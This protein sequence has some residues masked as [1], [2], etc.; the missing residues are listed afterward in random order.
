M[1]G[2]RFVAWVIYGTFLNNLK[3]RESDLD[4]KYENLDLILHSENKHQKSVSPH[5]QNDQHL[6][7]NVQLLHQLLATASPW[8]CHCNFRVRTQKSRVAEYRV[9]F[10]QPGCLSKT[11][12]LS[13]PFLRM[14]KYY[15]LSQKNLVFFISFM[16]ACQ[17]LF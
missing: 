14:V 5:H 13:A 15:R 16:R 10:R 9:I 1:T 8:D 17:L 7:R 6:L 4:T 11:L 3:I 2:Q 12:R